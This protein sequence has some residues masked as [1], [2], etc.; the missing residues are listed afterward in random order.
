M[1]ATRRADDPA[2]FNGPD[3][4][5]DEP[6]FKLGYKEANLSVKGISVF[7]ALSVLA[8]IAAILYGGWRTET[9]IATSLARLEQSMVA[10]QVV[11]GSEHR[12]IRLMQDRTSCIMTMSPER[13][14]RFRDRYTPGAFKQECPWVNE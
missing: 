8:I 9:T 6:T 12:S 7:I 3:F 13:R 14:D 5:S 11:D 1:S 4:R 2:D 10:V